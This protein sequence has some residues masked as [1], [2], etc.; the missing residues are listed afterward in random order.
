[1]RRLLEKIGMRD[2]GTGGQ[3]ASGLQVFGW[4]NAK[5]PRPGF[6][7]SVGCACVPQSGPGPLGGLCGRASRGQCCGYSYLRAGGN[8]LVVC[9]L[10]R[11][12]ESSGGNPDRRCSSQPEALGAA[13]EVTNG[14][15]HSKTRL[16]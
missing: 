15:K 12:V 13:Q 4:P 7:V 8:V 11:H 5:S 6:E 1:M 3:G 9:A 2:R 16:L 10:K 14:L